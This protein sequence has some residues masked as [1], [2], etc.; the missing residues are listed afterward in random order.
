M[1]VLITADTVGGVWTYA[2]DLV[3]AMPQHDFVLATMGRA[4]SSAQ[5][6]QLRPLP[7]C[8]LFE[9]EYNLE[10]MDDPW[11]DVTAAGKWLLDIA[12]RTGPDLVH[13]NGYAHG[14]LPWGVPSLVVAHSC[15]ASWWRA[16]KNE[17]LP[18]NWLQYRRAVEN[19]LNAV[20]LVVA[21]T[22][23]ML[24]ML[25][26]E[27]EVSRPTRVIRNGRDARRFAPETKEMRVVS[28]GRLWDE[29][30][31]IATL[32]A[33]APGIGC[34]VVVAGDAEAPAGVSTATFDRISSLGQ[35]PPDEVRTL[36]A[37]AAIYALPAR[38]EPFG[39]SVLEAALS[40]CALVLGDIPTLR[41]LW[42]GAAVF[43]DPNDVS[44]LQRGINQLVRDG[45]RRDAL[46]RAAQERARD[47]SVD[48]MATAYDETYT[49]LVRREAIRPVARSS[50]NAE[51]RA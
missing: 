42:N 30:K 2:V 33:A 40:G 34:P 8:T 1:K 46:A 11:D 41:E 5:R 12:D 45:A 17:P 50:Q 26:R 37:R 7:N 29:A 13:L 31:N 15:V 27:Y 14:L 36:L 6:E 51:A 18:D 43:V 38:Y 35:L 16:V 23:A 19:G 22:A 48:R 49:R 47:Y 3:T 21:P 28:A 32:A 10:W 39:L 44:G 24:R 4:L 25:E 9:S 20:D